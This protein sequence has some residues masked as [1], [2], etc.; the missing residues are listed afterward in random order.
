MLW[1]LPSS[2]R[3]R[4]DHF[5]RGRFDDDDLRFDRNAAGYGA[6][7]DLATISRV[8]GL[9]LH[10]QHPGGAERGQ[11]RKFPDQASRRKSE[12]GVSTSQ[13]IR[14]I[15]SRTGLWLMA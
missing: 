12:I 11:L 13:G 14:D 10:I 2:A 1:V 5:R 8:C 7:T 6:H 15:V 3:G 4:A 9:L